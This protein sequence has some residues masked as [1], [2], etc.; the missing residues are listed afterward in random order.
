MSNVPRLTEYFMSDNW[1]DEVNADNP[2]GMHGEIAT[3]YADLVK[4]IWSGKYSYTVPK[5]FKVWFMMFLFI[6]M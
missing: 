3:S 2:L 4:T 5:N 1:S 6:L